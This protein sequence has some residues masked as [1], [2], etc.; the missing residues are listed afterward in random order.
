MDLRCIKSY[1]EKYH[2]PCN[3]CDDH[4]LQETV[5]YLQPDKIIHDI[6]SHF[7]VSVG[8]II[9]NNRN[10]KYVMV[11]QL[12]CDMLY[13]DLFL[14]MSLNSIGKLLGG[15][16]HST[17]LHSIRQIKNHCQVDTDFREKYRQLHIF[18][19][20]TDKYFKYHKK[21]FDYIKENKVKNT[22]FHMLQY[23][24]LEL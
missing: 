21:Y 3:P 14:G 13:S 23:G 5:K 1:K 7:E 11:R 8:R 12:I 4:G 20:N 17:V 19:Y 16:D 15:R 10:A 2:I 9:G 6:C 24:T 18:I 22:K